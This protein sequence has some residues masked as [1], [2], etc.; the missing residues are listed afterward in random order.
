MKTKKSTVTAI[1]ESVSKVF[2]F[3]LSG[4][5]GPQGLY[6]YVS[7]NSATKHTFDVVAI[8]DELRKTPA[9]KTLLL[10]R[11]EA[12]KVLLN[13]AKKHAKFQS[14]FRYNNPK[15]DAYLI[16][17]DPRKGGCGCRY[18]TRDKTGA[19]DPTPITLK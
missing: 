7:T 6:A 15:V 1:A 12:L 19:W 16:F 11:K 14:V 17:C 5:P 18:G 2:N 8:D 4:Q 13:C 10:L 9:D 3:Y